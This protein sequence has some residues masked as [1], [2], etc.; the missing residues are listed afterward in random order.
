MRIHTENSK[1][2]TILTLQVQFE[3]IHHMLLQHCSIQFRNNS[4]FL[5]KR[6]HCSLCS[7][8]ATEFF[9]SLVPGTELLYFNNT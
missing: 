7:V 1:S 6:I 4:Y 9:V 2:S 3:L 5:M 8:L